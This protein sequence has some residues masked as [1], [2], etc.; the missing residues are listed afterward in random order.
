MAIAGAVFMLHDQAFCCQ[1]HRLNA[2][3]KAERAGQSAGAPSLN[4][5]NAAPLT[6]GLRASYATWM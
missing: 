4:A 5:T 2:Y 3:H 6:T 1:R